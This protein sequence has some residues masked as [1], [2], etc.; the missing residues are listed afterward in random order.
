MGGFI[1]VED[2][3]EHINPGIP[4]ADVLDVELLSDRI[5]NISDIAVN[6]FESGIER[7]AGKNLVQ[8]VLD[9]VRE[10][11]GIIDRDCRAELAV[12]A[13]SVDKHE[14]GISAQPLM[15]VA[16]HGVIESLGDISGI[17]IEDFAEIHI[18]D[19]A[20]EIPVLGIIPQKSPDMAGSFAD[21]VPVKSGAFAGI[22]L[23]T[24]PVAIFKPDFGPLGNPLEIMV[25]LDVRIQDQIGRLVWNEF[26][27]HGSGG[28]LH[29][30]FK[31]VAH[32]I[33]DR[34]SY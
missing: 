23:H 32:K 31:E 9:G 22:V 24:L 15:C 26:F 30:R 3:F 10:E 28:I 13:R 12:T 1:S 5:R 29:D 14:A 25:V 7:I 27:K 6:I 18:L 19:L 11:K 17:E 21:R 16:E 20:P 8:G 4:Q 34:S 2:G 33:G